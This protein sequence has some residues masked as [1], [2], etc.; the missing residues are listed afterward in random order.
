M[1]ERPCRSFALAPGLTVC[2]HCIVAVLKGDTSP[3]SRWVALA[4]AVGIAF[5]AAGLIVLLHAQ[6][7][8]AWTLAVAAVCVG[9]LIGAVLTEQRGIHPRV[10]PR[11]VAADGEEPDAT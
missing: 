3:A 6:G 10:A 1:P 7:V 5:A 11:I 2:R 9:A 4:W 8:L